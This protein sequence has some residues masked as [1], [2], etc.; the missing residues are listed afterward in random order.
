MDK[1]KQPVLYKIRVNSFVFNEHGKLLLLQ[2]RDDE[3][4]LP[5]FWETPGG[6]LESNETLEEGVVREVGE[7][8]G[9]DIK[10]HQIFSYSHYS[11]RHGSPTINLHFLAHMVNPSQSVSLHTNE[12]QNAAWVNLRQLSEYKMA[13]EMLA[14]CKQAFAS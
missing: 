4:F 11:D 1:R 13:D 12:M 8:A 5:G 7:E 3:K 6:A 14:L 10:V 9:I 2:K